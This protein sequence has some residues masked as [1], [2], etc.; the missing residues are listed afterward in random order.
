MV[1]LKGSIKLKLNYIS[2]ST[3]PSKTANSVHVMKMARAL[4]DE[5]IQVTLFARTTDAQSGQEDYEQYGVQRVFN[6][7]KVTVPGIKFIN[8]LYYAYKVIKTV[9][10][11][12]IP[13]EKDTVFYGRDLLTLVILSFYHEN[14]Y[15]EAHE[16]PTSLIRE[17]LVRTLLKSK[18]FKGL[19]VISNALKEEFKSR[20]NDQIEIN[21]LHDGADIN[22]VVVSEPVKNDM[23]IGYTGS[24]YKGRGIENIIEIANKLPKYKFQIVGGTIKQVLD[25]YSQEIELPSNIKVVGY[26]DPRE[27][28]AYIKK[29]TVV[30]APYQ[31]K[32]GISNPK[33]DTSKWMSPLKVFEYM[34]AEKPIVCSEIPVLKEVLKDNYNCLLID[35]ESIDDWVVAIT[36][37]IEDK[38]L[39]NRIAQQAKNDL[40][41]IYSW[42]VRAINIKKIINKTYC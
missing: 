15:Y 4:A 18:N 42:Q 10:K 2:G 28:P 5:G 9:K 20:Y 27:V 23:I 31:K 26:V 39:R 13:N 33:K 30:L 7:E 3:I 38:E 41:S 11:N 16:P 37:L 17:F 35:P 19:I 14:I 29:M 8:N 36:K 12:K 24:V 21:V 34:A 40:E 22:N 25:L 1:L 32:V 6:L